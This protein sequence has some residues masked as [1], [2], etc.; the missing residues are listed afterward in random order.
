VL[1]LVLVPRRVRVRVR[2]HRFIPVVLLLVVPLVRRRVRLVVVLLLPLLRVVGR[3]ISPREI[4]GSPRLVARHRAF[5]L[6]LV[7]GISDDVY[8][9]DY[10]L[11]DV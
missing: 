6:E 8:L 1:L 3:L 7:D 9:D 4:S 11:D 5:G 10:I 2:S